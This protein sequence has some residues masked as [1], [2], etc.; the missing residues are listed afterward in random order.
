MKPRST[1]LALVAVLVALILAAKD[2]IAYEFENL[3]DFWQYVWVV[4]GIMVA[5]A[6]AAYFLSPFVDLFFFIS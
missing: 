5:T 2:R 3:S 6:L 1:A 4:G